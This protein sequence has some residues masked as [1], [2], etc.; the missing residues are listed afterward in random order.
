MLY[1][2]IKDESFQGEKVLG[3]NKFQIKHLSRVNY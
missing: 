3:M 2:G 1:L